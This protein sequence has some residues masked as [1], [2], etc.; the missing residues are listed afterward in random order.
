MY[1]TFY[2]IQHV[3]E[4]GCYR[5]IPLKGSC[6]EHSEYEFDPQTRTLK[7]HGTGIVRELW[8]FD[9]EFSNLDIPFDIHRLDDEDEY[10]ISMYGIDAFCARFNEYNEDNFCTFSP[11]INKLIIDSGIIGIDHDAFYNCDIY[12][13]MLYSEV[14]DQKLRHVDIRLL[15][16]WHKDAVNSVFAE[17]FTAE[18]CHY[19]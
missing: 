16:I 11:H 3:A 2:T 5:R 10:Y 8:I 7:I 6:G 4:K 1:P 15:T 9:C 19:T 12:N 13:V 14:V 18:C 17:C